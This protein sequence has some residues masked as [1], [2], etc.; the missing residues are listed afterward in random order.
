MGAKILF[1]SVVKSVDL[2]GPDIHLANGQVMSADLI[3]GA[4]G[5]SYDDRK[6]FAAT[7]TVY[8]I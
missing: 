4:D 2:D 1:G 7:V 3:V 6:Y 5:T 8:T